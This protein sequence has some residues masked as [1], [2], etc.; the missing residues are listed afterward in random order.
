MKLS[1][2]KKFSRHLR[3]FPKRFA[4][5]PVQF[6]GATLLFFFLWFFATISFDGYIFWRYVTRL[7]SEL[8]DPDIPLEKLNT[9]N[10]EKVT[11]AIKSKEI[12][13]EE[14]A[15]FVPI[16]DIFL[17]IEFPPEQPR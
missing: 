14:I 5:S 9:A 17:P 15:S 12:A 13:T 1:F 3:A 4:S 16:R 2:P 6:W 8:Q 10:Y 7:D 11:N